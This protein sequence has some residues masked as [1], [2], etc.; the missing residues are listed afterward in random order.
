MYAGVLFDWDGTLADTRKVILASFQQALKT[1]GV[2]A[3][4]VYIERRIG[5]G[6]ELTFKE[7]LKEAGKPFDDTL[8]KR[9]I[10]EKVKAEI[11]LADKVKLFPGAKDLLEALQGKVK[12]ALASMNNR[13]V[14]N[15]LL[16]TMSIESCFDEVVTVE[17]VEKSKPDPEIFLKAATKLAVSPAECVVVED[18][19][20]G[21]QA[22]KTAGIACIAV[23]TGVYTRSELEKA[24]P[25]LIVNSLKEQEKIRDF[26]FC[27][28]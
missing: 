2:Q 23:R 18:S 21:V 3:D 13:P 27:A 6:A 1:V 26:I 17:E 22:A 28:E 4:A 5:I 7:T 25:A 11:N 8:I 14:I 10:E 16:R 9:L 24:S 19:I 20:F 12:L 15:H